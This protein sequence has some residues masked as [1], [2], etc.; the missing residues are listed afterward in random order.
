MGVQTLA[1]SKFF[2]GPANETADDAAA[3]RALNTY[4]EVGEIEDF[5][6]FGD[7][8]A[9]TNFTAVNNRRVRKFKTTFDAG[10][11]T[12]LLGMDSS[13]TG[14]Q[15]LVAALDSDSDFAIK[16]TLDDSDETDSD[17][18]PTTFFFRAKVISNER[19]LG[20][21]DNV[22]RRSVGIALNSE[23]IEIEPGNGDGI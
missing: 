20:K 7:K 6:N 17:A 3:Y 16:V 9:T 21:V 14:Q 12:L 23:V 4:V 10:E 8:V 5:G 13:D 2:I 19:Q 11:M 22:V 15:A 1:G 18:T